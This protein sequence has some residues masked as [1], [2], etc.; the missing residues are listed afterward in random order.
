[1]VELEL[2]QVR[3]SIP[4]RRLIKRSLGLGRARWSICV[5]G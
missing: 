4:I 1:M 5:G 2:W 3:R